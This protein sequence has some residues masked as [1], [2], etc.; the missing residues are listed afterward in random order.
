[1]TTILMI[2]YFVQLTAAI[3]I[4][5]SQPE[6]G[7]KTISYASQPNLQGSNLRSSDL[8]LTNLLEK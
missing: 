2:S 8:K 1:M 4:H 5:R 3:A 7:F 6:G